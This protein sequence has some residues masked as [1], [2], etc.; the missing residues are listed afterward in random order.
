MTLDLIPNTIYMK[1][2]VVLMLEIAVKIKM[3]RANA[4]LTQD[5]FA[6]LLNISRSKVSKWETSIQYPDIAD[7][8]LLKSHFQINLDEFLESEPHLQQPH[9]L[10]SSSATYH[11]SDNDVHTLLML[12]QKY[13]DLKKALQKL[14]SLP[15]VPQK[16][17][18]NTITPLFRQLYTLSNKNKHDNLS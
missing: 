1:K 16:E 9:K 5:Q 8:L 7:C 10:N 11:V 13:P 3:L 14:H 17:L 6:K 18:L 15:E 4:G 12:F 2:E